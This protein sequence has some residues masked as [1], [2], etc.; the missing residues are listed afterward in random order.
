MVQ[1]GLQRG[2]NSPHLHHSVAVAHCLRSAEFRAR[3]LL[4]P[5]RCGEPLVGVEQVAVVVEAEVDLGPID[6]CRE[7]A[8]RRGE[9][10]VGRR[11]ALCG[12]RFTSIGDR[13]ASRFFSS[14]VIGPT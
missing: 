2:F 12:G 10:L 11:F 13:L 6:S 5:H 4:V 8:L 1:K 9:A 3:A 14:N 7:A